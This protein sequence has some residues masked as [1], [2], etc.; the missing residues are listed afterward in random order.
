M[1]SQKQCSVLFCD[2]VIKSAS[3]SAAATSSMNVSK[4]QKDGDGI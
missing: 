2:L 3:S 4:D 1:L